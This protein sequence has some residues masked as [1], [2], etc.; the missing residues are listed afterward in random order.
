[1]CRS[2]HEDRARGTE[3]NTD[4]SAA[5]GTGGWEA[6]NKGA[7]ADSALNQGAVFHPLVYLF[8]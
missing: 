2:V 5:G 6:S 8:I 7:R 1:M 4:S 3:D